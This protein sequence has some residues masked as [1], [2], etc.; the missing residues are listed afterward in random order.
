M[1]NDIKVKSLGEFTSQLSELST[2]IAEGILPYHGSFLFRGQSNKDYEILPSVERNRFKK[3]VGEGISIEDI[4]FKERNLIAMAKFELPE[5][6]RDD[7]QPI[8]LLALL[9]HHGIPTRLLDVTQN[10]MVALYFA[11]ASSHKSDGEVIVF[12]DKRT[13]ID[14]YPIVNAIADSYRF[15]NASYNSLSVFFDKVIQQPYFSEQ[16]MESSYLWDTEKKK[17]AWIEECCKDPI[18]IHSK[19]LVMR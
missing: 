6:F 18:F 2:L 3:M 7:L 12:W 13:E 14:N 16:R 9:Q 4:C 15:A 19:M 5:I 11:C 1:S 10:A 17:S 8:D